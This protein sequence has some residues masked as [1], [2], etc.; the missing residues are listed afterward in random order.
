[1][2]VLLGQSS[3]NFIF[4]LVEAHEGAHGDLGLK[5]GRPLSGQT[6]RVSHINAASLLRRLST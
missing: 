5:E 4:D 3:V 6:L 2:C 1:M